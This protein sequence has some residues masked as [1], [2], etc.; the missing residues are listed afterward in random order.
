MADET[1]AEAQAKPEKS[2]GMVGKLVSGIGILV[3]V[4]VGNL[5]TNFIVRDF[6]PDLAP[7]AAA[8]DE[9]GKDG[10][11]KGKDGKKD[12]KPVGP[13]IYLAMDPPLV[14][15]ID[16]GESIRFLQITIEVMSRTQPTLD[17]VMVHTPKIRNDLL[18]LLGRKEITE[19]TSPDGKEQL[20]Q[21]ALGVVQGIL[22]QMGPAKQGDE[23]G[24]VEDLYFTSFVVQ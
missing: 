22:K 16:D 2:G 3:L 9:E 10:K 11:G 4:I 8:A 17:A 13:P 12:E 7:V 24:E 5:A 20:R 23:V 14:A 15:S 1:E 21:E 6:M 19:L 18:M